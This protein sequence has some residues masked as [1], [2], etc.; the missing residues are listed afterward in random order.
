MIR[1]LANDILPFSVICQEGQ[2]YNANL[3]QC[4]SCLKGY[5]NNGNTTQRFQSC[6]ACPANYTT[7]GAGNA[8]S[9]YDCDTLN[10]E[11]GSFIDNDTGTV[12]GG[13]V[14]GFVVVV[15]VAVVMLLLMLL[16]LLFFAIFTSN[17]GV[18]LFYWYSQAY[19]KKE[20]T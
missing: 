15:V 5:W 8:T 20:Y 18:F 9:E 10:C 3:G 14:I 16:L 7:S 17:T 19:I 13:N 2:G 1:S 6:K 12:V 4:E 11:P